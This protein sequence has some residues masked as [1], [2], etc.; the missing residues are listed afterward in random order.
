[1]DPMLPLKGGVTYTVGGQ[2]FV[3]RPVPATP[4]P[5]DPQDTLYLDDLSPTGWSMLV[6]PEGVDAGDMERT[7]C[8]H[9]RSRSD[10]LIDLDDNVREGRTVRWNHPGATVSD[11]PHP[12][13]RSK[14]AMMRDPEAPIACGTCGDI[15]TVELSD[16]D[17]DGREQSITVCAT[18][19]SDE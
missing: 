9:G 15:E 6:V 17:L 16:V 18:C 3:T 2:T 19:G 14:A 13:M 5:I 10:T 7:Y 1:M 8:A 11:H 12:V 4:A